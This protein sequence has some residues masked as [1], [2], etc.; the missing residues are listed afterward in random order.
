MS[1]MI[2]QRWGL[3]LSSREILGSE[4]RQ[5]GWMSVERIVYDNGVTLCLDVDISNA[6]VKVQSLGGDSR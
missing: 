5:A 1:R 3:S 4:G 6:L 2:G